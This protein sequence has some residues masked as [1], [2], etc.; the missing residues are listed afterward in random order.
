MCIYI[1][2]YIYILFN[3]TFTY[4]V[5]LATRVFSWCS[6]NTLGSVKF[7]PLGEKRLISNPPFAKPPFGSSRCQNH[8]LPMFCS[9]PQGGPLAG[10]SQR[11]SGRNAPLQGLGV[12]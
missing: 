11:D 6:C 5:S 1:Y 4:T 3:Y 12:P 2:I 10:C 8:P 7:D 9:F